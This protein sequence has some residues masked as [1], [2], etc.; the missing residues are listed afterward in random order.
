MSKYMGVVVMIV[1]SAL[2]TCSIVALYFIHS[3]IW[4]LVFIILFG[5]VFATALAFFTD[6]KSV[7]IF[8]ASV[9]LA[10]VQVVFVGTAFGNGNRTGNGN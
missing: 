2:P 9:A 5:G 4:R 1:A 7:E 6:A 8:T 3:P 10:S